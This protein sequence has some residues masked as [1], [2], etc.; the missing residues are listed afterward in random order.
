MV[1]YSRTA[2]SRQEN[3]RKRDPHRGNRF[4]LHTVMFHSTTHLPQSKSSMKKRGLDHMEGEQKN[5][6]K[7]KTRVDHY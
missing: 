1:R 2:L 7:M 5:I 4:F 3:E 6:E